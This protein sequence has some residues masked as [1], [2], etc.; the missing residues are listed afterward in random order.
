MYPT[1]LTELLTSNVL[2]KGVWLNDDNTVW[3]LYE[4]EGFSFK[5]SGEILEGVV[6]KKTKK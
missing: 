2:I 1:E 3:H 4:V 6:S 5:S